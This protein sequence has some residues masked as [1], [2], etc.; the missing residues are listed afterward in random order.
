MAVQYTGHVIYVC[1]TWQR[2]CIWLSFFLYSPF[3]VFCSWYLGCGECL[4]CYIFLSEKLKYKWWQ[5]EL[6][7]CFLLFW[8]F[9]F[10]YYFYKS[11]LARGGI[12]YKAIEIKKMMRL[13]LFF[14][15]FIIEITFHLLS[16]HH[17]S[18]VHSVSSHLF[19][20]RNEITVV[21]LCRYVVNG[22]K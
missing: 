6:F 13:T 20:C 7:M 21:I 2:Y 4:H 22:K 11:D 8:E 15:K 1:I 16:H 19:L 5:I 10:F 9:L 3:N 18:I 17:V 14:F 12:L